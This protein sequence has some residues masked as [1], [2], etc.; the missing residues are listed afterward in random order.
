MYKVHV[1]YKFLVKN[2]RGNNFFRLVQIETNSTADLLHI[3]A[4][5]K[6]NR[7][8]YDF[9][10]RRCECISPLGPVV[11]INNMVIAILIFLCCQRIKNTSFMKCIE[12]H[13]FFT[14]LSKRLQKQ[15]SRGVFRK[16]CSKNMEKISKR[17]PMP[18]CDFNK[19][20]RQLLR[21]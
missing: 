6:Q 11:F 8:I 5:G 16:K 2:V 15:P 19:K 12:S 14:F 10:F 13:I 18:K 3:S 21:C 20:Q 17:T 4:R 1:K 7:T 9:P